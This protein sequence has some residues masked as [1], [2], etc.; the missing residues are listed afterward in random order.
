MFRFPSD[1]E[2]QKIWLRAIP[3]KGNDGLLKLTTNLRVCDLHF[4]QDDFEVEISASNIWRKRRHDQVQGIGRKMSRLKKDAIPKRFPNLPKYLSIELPKPR[5]P[6]ALKF[7][8]FQKQEEHLNEKIS[9]F[10]A[11]ETF[12]NLVT[13][14]EKLTRERVP[15]DVHILNKQGQ[16]ILM[17]ISRTSSRII[18]IDFFLEIHEDPSFQMQIGECKI[19]CDEVK[20]IVPK[21]T[22]SKTSEVLNVLAFLRSRI[23]DRNESLRLNDAVKDFIEKVNHKNHQNVFIICRFFSKGQNN[24]N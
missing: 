13:L 17:S 5:S 20:H 12:S 19:P 4:T 22:F 2:K 10:F 1:P 6:A 24:S 14:S 16:V 11:L 21:L 9:S 7:S 8:R 18:Q 3:R 23:S 15:D